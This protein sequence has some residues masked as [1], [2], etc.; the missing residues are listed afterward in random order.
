MVN[1]AVSFTQKLGIDAQDLALRLRWLTIDDADRER[2][3]AAAQFLEPE[4]ETIVKY[5]TNFNPNEDWSV[6]TD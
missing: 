5:I 3:R 6:V 2:I 4:T 1:Q